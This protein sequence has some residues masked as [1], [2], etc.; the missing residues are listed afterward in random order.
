M[1]E[2][3]KLGISLK[4]TFETDVHE[5]KEQK[6]GCPLMLLGIVG[7]NVSGNLFSGTS[8]IRICVGFI[9]G[10]CI[11]KACENFW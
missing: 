3:K 11:I 2:L 8:L 9:I 5:M 10:I 1:K 6:D 4:G 7:A